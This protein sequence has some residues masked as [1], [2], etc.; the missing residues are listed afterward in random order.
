MLKFSK[1]QIWIEGFP[2]PPTANK[3]LFISRG[4]FI[5]SS[6]AR[7]FDKRVEFFRFKN[8]KQLFEANLILQIWMTEGFL[9]NVDTYFVSHESKLLTKKGEIKS[10]DSNNF[11]KSSLDGLVKTIG[12]DDK[13]FVSGFYEKILCKSLNEDAQVLIRLSK[14]KLRT[15]QALKESRVL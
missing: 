8:S 15:L 13:Y 5:K 4:R 14:A 12:I 7:E 3:Q 9:I 1:D 6:L 10:R 11:L 2:L